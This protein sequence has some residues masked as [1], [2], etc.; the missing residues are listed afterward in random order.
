MV[1]RITHL[2]VERIH[3]TLYKF[4]FDFLTHN[5]KSFLIGNIANLNFISPLSKKIHFFSTLQSRK[6]PTNGEIL[7]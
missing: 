2:H 5:S 3:R 6:D 7:D 1:A 4:L